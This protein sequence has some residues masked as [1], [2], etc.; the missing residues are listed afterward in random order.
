MLAAAELRLA[1]QRYKDEVAH[2]LATNAEALKTIYRGTT[3]YDIVQQT[4]RLTKAKGELGPRLMQHAQ[5]KLTEARTYFEHQFASTPTALAVED[6]SDAPSW[7]EVREA[8]SLPDAA[9]STFWELA[10]KSWAG[11]QAE[12]RRQ[13]RRNAHRGFALSEQAALLAAADPLAALRETMARL[14]PPFLIQDSTALALGPLLR[15]S[16]TLANDVTTRQEINRSAQRELVRMREQWEKSIS[17]DG[18]QLIWG[19]VVLL[20]P[21]VLGVVLPVMELSTGASG[22]VR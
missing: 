19:L 11:D 2:E 1:E 12:R 3:D 20:L 18:R 14:P 16:D 21:T 8:E 6:W 4:Y 10:Y 7:Q 15:R 17:P 22:R 5:E 13:E 9:W